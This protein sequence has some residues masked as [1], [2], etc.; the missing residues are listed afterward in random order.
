MY[1]LPGLIAVTASGDGFVPTGQISVVTGIATEVASGAGSDTRNFVAEEQLDDVPV[2]HV[3][4]KYA[5][6]PGI[7]GV[8]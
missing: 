8:R 2:S 6:S 1:D 5:V 4:P 7:T 3:I